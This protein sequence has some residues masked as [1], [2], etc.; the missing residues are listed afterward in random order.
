MSR[1]RKPYFHADDVVRIEIVDPTDR[2]RN[3]S[4]APG[5]RSVILDCLDW[6]L[7]QQILTVHGTGGSGSPGRYI[8]YYS[9]ADAMRIGTWLNEHDVWTRERK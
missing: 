3:G 5:E 1:T 4:L 2:H 8:G 6:A 9:H 7:T